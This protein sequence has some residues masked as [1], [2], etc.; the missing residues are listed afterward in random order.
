MTFT[1]TGKPRMARVGVGLGGMLTFT[2]TG[3]P[4]MAHSCGGVDA[5]LHKHGQINGTQV[6]GG[7][8][9]FTDTGKL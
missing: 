4:R 1:N 7:M 2:G 6:W 5:N 8:L 9:A 3:K